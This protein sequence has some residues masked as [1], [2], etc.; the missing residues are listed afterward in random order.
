MLGYVLLERKTYKSTNRFVT[1]IGG[2]LA[3]IKKCSR[4]SVP[5]I[6]H[7]PSRVK[8]SPRFVAVYSVNVFCILEIFWND[9]PC[10]VHST[11]LG[12]K[13]CICLPLDPCAR[14]RRKLASNECT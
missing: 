4:T 14:L 11:S 12:R 8:F 9:T 7:D 6:F 5:V 2:P 10:L 13:K 1:L 3:L